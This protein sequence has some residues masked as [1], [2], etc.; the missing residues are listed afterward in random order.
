MKKAILRTNNFSESYKIV[1]VLKNPIS[2]QNN[3]ALIKIENEEFMTGGLLCD[4]NQNTL[5]VLDK[6]SN[7]E[8]WDWLLSILTFR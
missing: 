6:L 4:V 1:E 5:E 2:E 7:K 3:L 8:Q